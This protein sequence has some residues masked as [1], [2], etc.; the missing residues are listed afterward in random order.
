EADLWANTPLTSREPH[1]LVN[2]RA[3]GR[4]G[5]CST[6]RPF[7]DGGQVSFPIGFGV[8]IPGILQADGFFVIEDGVVFKPGRCLYVL[9]I[10]VVDVYAGAVFNAVDDRT[11]QVKRDRRAAP[12]A[13]QPAVG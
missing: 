8:H 5:L 4:D 12:G 10:R 2:L 1:A 7:R 11:R 3:D 9:F 13:T 6:I